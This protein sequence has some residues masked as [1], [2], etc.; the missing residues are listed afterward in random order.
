MGGFG[1]REKVDN[2]EFLFFFFLVKR[3]FQHI[4]FALDDNSSLTDQDTNQSLV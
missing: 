1:N 2:Q 4:A 3:E